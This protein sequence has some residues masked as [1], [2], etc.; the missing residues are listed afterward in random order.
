MPNCVTALGS[1]TRC[2]SSMDVVRRRG[3]YVGRRQINVSPKSAKPFQSAADIINLNLGELDNRDISR[4]IPKPRFVL[5]NPQTDITMKIQ[6]SP[7]SIPYT[8]PDLSQPPISKPSLP[9]VVSPSPEI[10]EKNYQLL[11][12][13]FDS[14]LT[15]INA[16]GSFSYHVA[17]E[18]TGQQD[19]CKKVGDAAQTVW[20]SAKGVGKL[21]YGVGESVYNVETLNFWPF[22]LCPANTWGCGWIYNTSLVKSMRTAIIAGS[23]IG[24][25]AIY[26]V[27][28]RRNVVNVKPIINVNVPT[29]LPPVINNFINTS[30]TA[31]QLDS[32]SSL[33]TSEDLHKYR[34]ELQYAA[35]SAKTHS[36]LFNPVWVSEISE[37]VDRDDLKFIQNRYP[38]CVKTK[39]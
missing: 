39:P 28:F 14:T 22:S 12:N 5:L 10:S 21:L 35:L 19:T 13:L 17:C 24:G 37:Y 9:S 2:F 26:F 32:T 29:A 4:S 36:R 23:I 20:G 6:Q 11:R 18:M 27:V 1:Y 25:L 30:S 3:F 7:S 31:P 8:A 16:A 15:G 34:E 33:G 38:G